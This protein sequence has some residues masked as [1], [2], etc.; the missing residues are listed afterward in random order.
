MNKRKRKKLAKRGNCFHYLDYRRKKF[1]PKDEFRFS[2]MKLVAK[3][4]YASSMF[5]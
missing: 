5:V 4:M 3:K 2:A 1:V